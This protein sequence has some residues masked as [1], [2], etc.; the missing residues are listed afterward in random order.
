MEPV[1]GPVAP[2]YAALQKL[3]AHPLIAWVTPHEVPGV[4]IYDPRSLKFVLGESQFG[5]GLVMER[6][7][8]TQGYEPSPLRGDGYFQYHEDKGLIQPRGN[9]QFWEEAVCRIIYYTDYQ[10][11]DIYEDRAYKLTDVLERCGFE[12]DIQK[13]KKTKGGA[14]LLGSNGFK[15]GFPP[16]MPARP[17]YSSVNP[18]REAYDDF[19]SA[20]TAF[21][22]Y[23]VEDWPNTVYPYLDR[24]MPSYI[25][26]QMNGIAEQVEKLKDGMDKL[27]QLKNP[28]VLQDG[29]DQIIRMRTESLYGLFES[30]ERMTK[31]EL[32]DLGTGVY[33]EADEAYDSE[34][35]NAK[36]DYRG[37]WEVD[38]RPPEERGR[39]KWE[40][41]IKTSENWLD[42]EDDLG[43]TS[44]SIA[45]LQS[46]SSVEHKLS[47]YMNRG[48]LTVQQLN[49]VI[50][51]PR[52]ISNQDV[53]GLGQALGWLREAAE[54][55]ADDPEYMADMI[56]TSYSEIY[57]LCLKAQGWLAPK[58][59][60][61]PPQ[62]GEMCYL[63]DDE[64]YG[65]IVHVKKLYLLDETY[66]LYGLSPF[67]YDGDNWISP[68]TGTKLWWFTYDETGPESYDDQLRNER[69]KK[70]KR[71]E[72]ERLKWESR[73][74]S[75]G[76]SFSDGLD[77]IPGLQR[78]NPIK[79]YEVSFDIGD[80]V[81]REY[82]NW[83]NEEPWGQINLN[84]ATVRDVY[85]YDEPTSVSMYGY[86]YDLPPG[87]YY[88]VQWDFAMNDYTYEL[89]KPGK[90]GEHVPEEELWPEGHPNLDRAL[91][92]PQVDDNPEDFGHERLATVWEHDRCPECDHR[93][94]EDD[95]IWYC[96]N[97]GYN[98]DGQL[99]EVIPFPKRSM[100][101]RTGHGEI[102]RLIDLYISENPEITVER[103]GYDSPESFGHVNGYQYEE[104]RYDP[105]EVPDDPDWKRDWWEENQQAWQNS[106]G[107]CSL[108]TMHFI[109]WLRDRGL[110]AYS[111]N[112]MEAMYGDNGWKLDESMSGK[113]QLGYENSP[114]PGNPY[115]D[116]HCAA[117]IDWKG[118]TFLIDW[119]ATQY[120]HKEWP[121]VKQL[122][123]NKQWQ[124]KWSAPLDNSWLKS[125]AKIDE[126]KRRW[127]Q[128]DAAGKEV[129]DS[130]AEFRRM[131]VNMVEKNPKTD[132]LVLWMARENK[133]NFEG[134]WQTFG[135]ETRLHPGQTVDDIFGHWADFM[136]VRPR[137]SEARRSVGD[138]MQLS[139][140]EFV[141]KVRAWDE[142]LAAKMEDEKTKAVGGTGQV[143]FQLENG[144][145]VRAL[146]D[147]KS[148]ELEGDAMGHCVGGYGEAVENLET[149]IFSLRDNKGMP[150]ATIEIECE[151]Y[152]HE[153]FDEPKHKS[154]IN[155]SVE[156]IQIEGDY[157][158]HVP[159]YV[160][161]GNRSI[162][163][164][165]L[166]IP[167]SEIIPLPNK[168]QVIQ[169]Q[170]KQNREPIP[171]YKAMLRQWFESFDV[172]ER[173]QDA[174][175]GYY[176]GDNDYMRNPNL[177]WQPHA[178]DSRFVKN[179][180]EYGLVGEHDIWGWDQWLEQAYEV[181]SYRNQSVNWNI[182]KNFVR[183]VNMTGLHGPLVKEY[184]DWRQ[185]IEEDAFEQITYN[186]H[187]GDDL[188][189]PEIDE[190]AYYEA[191]QEYQDRSYEQWQ[192]EDPYGQI[193]KYIDQELYKNIHPDYGVNP[194]G[195][196]R[197]PKGNWLESPGYEWPKWS[198]RDW[199]SNLKFAKM[200]ANMRTSM[201]APSDRE[202][203]YWDH[204]EIDRPTVEQIPIGCSCQDDGIRQS[205]GKSPFRWGS[206][207][208]GCPLHSH[209]AEWAEQSC[210]YRVEPRDWNSSYR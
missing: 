201:P 122:D 77:M 207:A 7:D 204:N 8:Q 22:D 70:Y 150:H 83:I 179:I 174:D 157:T 113:A 206:R 28:G 181:A 42:E 6:Y 99:A 111:T 145:T 59:T 24:A 96:M 112:S 55:G 119:T 195:W 136:A 148:C 21:S 80:R 161:H 54:Y 166:I 116:T 114:E 32:G 155:Q 49:E 93:L 52:M 18:L 126:L 71:P 33:T 175:Q 131:L 17:T 129:S 46:L 51:T 182:I 127:E 44:I 152:T 1:P 149:G 48:P 188:P 73:V 68:Q 16:I 12:V 141:E 118:E 56:A 128:S 53:P 66:T 124:E 180:N 35:D 177:E 97:C 153:K 102:D 92:G 159:C 172:E 103:D 162:D 67:Q 2:A 154:D 170:G 189:D 45:S 98:D 100:A 187:Y 164:E 82:N 69:L 101:E 147:A 194:Q 168:G 107:Y 40:S 105:S 169:I 78:I 146:S 50:R 199:T 4:Y 10:N 173:P 41:S 27:I 57:E 132:P 178:P 110:R 191:L 192:L 11:S 193:I 72:G 60:Q 143:V 64:I 130:E 90:M 137:E 138:I 43:G 75:D 165:N 160:E 39:L 117:V 183:Y 115:D 47:E 86:E 163:E 203:E 31:R 158:N 37:Q 25:Q 108:I 104:D 185:G 26:A 205:A 209:R 19:D 95:G 142:E 134:F 23:P 76:L 79:N 81:V 210:Y 133:K 20:Y 3:K 186:A 202:L 9:I 34:I 58:R 139:A 198:K 30:I 62:Q 36:P 144:W 85:K 13:Y 190:D 61:E 135:R 208:L 151:Y 15:G 125:A 167:L 5:H 197:D 14:D 176:Y 109:D 94:W 106:T 120:G 38:M 74:A 171:K 91:S 87:Q 88:D 63:L 29:W 196:Q 121:M 156:M 200:Y 123:D 65:R 140:S 89:S 184:E 84:A